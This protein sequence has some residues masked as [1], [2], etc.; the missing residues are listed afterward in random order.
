MNRETFA[1]AA[2]KTMFAK[3]TYKF[4]IENINFAVQLDLST[5]EVDE[6]CAQFLSAHLRTPGCL[7]RSCS[8]SH[9]RMSLRS[10]CIIFESLGDSP[11]LELYLDSNILDEECCHVL[12]ISLSRSPPLEVLSLVGCQIGP[13]AANRFSACLS[14]TRNLHHLRLDSNSIYSVGLATL[15]SLEGSLLLESL[16]ISDNQIWADEMSLLLGRLQTI[17]VLKS[18]DIGFNALD[19]SVLNNYVNSS[20]SLE[21]ICISGCKVQKTK[22]PDFL[23]AVGRSKVKTLMI[24]SLD[25]N[26]TTVIWPYNN[27]LSWSVHG[28]LQNLINC[29]RSNEFLSDVRVGFLD[30]D[31]ISVLK[32]AFRTLGNRNLILTVHNFGLTGNVWSM[33]W[34]PTFVLDSPVSTWRWCHQLNP[35]LGQQMG[36]LFNDVECYGNKF[37]SIDMNTLQLTDEIVNEFLSVIEPFALKSLNLSE[38]EALKGSIEAVSQFIEAG[39]TIEDLNC[40]NVSFALIHVE[41]LFTLFTQIPLSIQL[42]FISEP[43]GELSLQPLAELIGRLIADDTRLEELS[44]TGYISC[45]DVGTMIA[46]LGKNTHLKIM[47]F[48]SNYFMEYDTPDPHLD[49]MIQ[50]EFDNLIELLYIQLCGRDSLSVAHYFSFPLLTEIFLH[51]SPNLIKWPLVLRSLDQNR[52]TRIV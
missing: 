32:E 44:L 17:D 35:S 49:P 14:R 1:N 43:I 15:I 9:C 10:C 42:G 7:L 22:V 33:R 46:S 4:L 28:L 25:F 39:G 45:R 11:L 24:D 30:L 16:S 13:N 50:N 20:K 2:N 6:S 26:Q 8:L 19:L 51:Q 31:A 36:Q 21:R 48:Q 38:N 47:D 27:D 52:P 23:E 5:N 40:S 41:R 37:D 12:A 34:N 29:I 18:L 3:N